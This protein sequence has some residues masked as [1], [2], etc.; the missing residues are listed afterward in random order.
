VQTGLAILE[1]WNENENENKTKWN[2][3]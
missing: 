3:N 2:I 1:F